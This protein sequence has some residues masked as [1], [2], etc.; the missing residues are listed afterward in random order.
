MNRRNLYVVLGILLAL[1]VFHRPLLA[2]LVDWWWF[3]ALGYADIF[4]I[5]LSAK[6]GLWLTGFLVTSGVILANISLATREAP[7]NYRRMAMLVAERGL[8]PQQMRTIVRL[9]V[10]VWVIFPSFLFA[11]GSAA[12]WLEVLTFVNGGDFG[13]VDPVFG[14]DTGFYVFKL[15]LLEYLQDAVTGLLL[16]TLLPLLGFYAV[17]DLL[18]NHDT[19]VG[20]STRARRHLLFLGALIFLG[21]AGGWY[22]ERFSLLTEQTLGGVVWGVGYTDENATLPAM[23]AMVGFC[24]LSA[25]ALGACLVKYDWRIP[26][27]AVGFYFLGALGANGLV[28]SMVQDYVVKPSELQKESDYLVR[29]IE[30]TRLAYDLGDV[31]VR[32][33]EAG[34]GLTKE[35]IDAN[36]LTIDNVRIWDDRPL[37]TTYAQIQEIRLYYEFMDVDIDRYTIDG[38]PRQ[39]MLAARELKYSNV[40]ANAQSWVNE[41]F[42]Y[43]HGYG[44]TVSPVNVV[45]TEGMPELWVQDIPPVSVVPELNVNRPE[46][47]YGEMTDRYVFVGTEA[48]EF[49]YPSGDE[50]VYANYDGAGGVPVGEMW[51]RLVFASWF[52]SFDIVLSTYLT[53]ESRVMFRRR[54]MDRVGT[55]APF[56]TLDQDPY[57][58][59]DGEGRLKWMVDAYTTTDRAPYSEP[60]QVSRFHR[61]NYIRNSVKVVVDAYDGSID[62]YIS[63]ADDPLIKAYAQIF[64]GSFKPLDEMPDSLQAHVR[65]PGDLFGH[66]IEKYRAYHMKDPTVFYNKEDM[67]DR[68]T[69]TYQ[70][71]PVQMEPYYLIMKLPEEDEG[72]FILLMPFVP[73]KKDNMISWLAARSDGD[74]YGKLVLY[75]FPK[76]KLV[77]GPKQIEARIDQN[78]EISAQLTLWDQSGSSVLRGNLLVIP[79]EDS[80]MYVEPV[81][82]KAD[83]G[84]LPELKRV[85]VSYEDMV[86]MESTL[87]AALARVFGDSA[88]VIEVVEGDD[89]GLDVAV[90]D[91]TFTELAT[92]ANDAY[93]QAVDAQRSGDWAAYGVALDQLGALLERMAVEGG[94]EPTD[95]DDAGLE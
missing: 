50:N 42:Q 93:T 59:I 89:T 26:A 66:Q 87:E 86:V 95:E 77:Y 54:V 14:L 1:W 51:R 28:P 76:Q 53:E 19:H 18:I 23:N 15:P 90:I 32:P 7:I 78:P 63:D 2:V 56:L 25:A 48:Q 9:M 88:P 60:T 21:F 5:S 41:H 84:E 44:V 8:S 11:S 47:Y 13:Q 43:T 34:E 55:V 70:G 64:E 61:F 83:Q 27:G 71:S 74:A 69:E 57:L 73:T 36:P 33:F 67:W 75:S 3:D 39:V 35:V 94:T 49:D 30:G 20:L 68:P 22:L 16:V 82:L 24:L 91:Q 80:I 79:I 38:N 45:T 62:F 65:Y 92:A 52:G 81:Y 12:M 6:L 4:T 46:I 72:E 17:R 37:Q 31:E 58:V 85:I 40:P 10:G 29:N